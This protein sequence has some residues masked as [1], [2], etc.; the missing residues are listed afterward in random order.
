MSEKTEKLEAELL[1]LSMGAS[2]A[3]E[4]CGICGG[5]KGHNHK[6]SEFYDVGPDLIAFSMVP[7]PLCEACREPMEYL[8]RG[9]DWTCRDAVCTAFNVPVSTGIGGVVSVP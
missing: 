1:R 7:A 6:L 2:V 3:H 5:P 4:A 9:T 8:N